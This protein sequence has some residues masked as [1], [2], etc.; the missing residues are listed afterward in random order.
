MIEGVV[1]LGQGHKI[2]Y[3]DYGVANG[4][5][6]PEFHVAA[7]AMA[8]PRHAMRHPTAIAPVTE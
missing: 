8:V 5:S 3:A 2:G 4:T 6:S 7:I 1:A